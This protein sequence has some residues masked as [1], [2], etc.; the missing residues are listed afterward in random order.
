MRKIMICLLLIT[1]AAAPALADTWS[2]SVNAAA[3]A[4]IEIPADGTLTSLALEA[5]QRVT[6]GEAVGG[7]KET[8][9]FAPADGTVAAI[10]LEIGDEADGTV[11]EI[12]PV[13]QYTLTCTAESYAKTPENALIH[14]G[15]TVYVR[16]TAD[17]SHRALARVT[18]ING[19]AFNA[20]VTGGELYVGETVFIYRQS[21]FSTDSLIGKGTV[22]THDTL[23]VKSSGTILS[24]R[25]SVGDEVERGQWLFSTASSDQTTV[26]VPMD[27][28]VTAVSAQ[29]GSTV[30]ENQSVATIATDI[31][32]RVEVSADDAPRFKRGEI[33]Y[34]TRNDDSHEV[35]HT[36]T[37]QRVLLNEQDASATIVLNPEEH[38]LPIGM[39][40]IL[41]DEKVLEIADQVKDLKANIEE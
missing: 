33:W 32:L 9:V 12:S 39:G 1:L 24:M 4:E 15:E 25:V 2:G 7:I 5:G 34:Y 23:A 11:L 35:H 8:K 26:I 3:T 40:I 41:T 31:S 14:S 20:E 21:D 22:T 28:I 37:V 36:A 6:A 10:H 19:A 13:S 17:G 18:T 30:K 27:G 38:D 29:A 16:C